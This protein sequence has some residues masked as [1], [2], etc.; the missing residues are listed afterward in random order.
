MGG[1]NTALDGN[2]HEISAR[3]SG[4]RRNPVKR[5]VRSTR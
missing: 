5:D 1:F 2:D 4:E 3:H